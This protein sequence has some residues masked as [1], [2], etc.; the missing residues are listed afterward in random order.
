VRSG[1]GVVVAGGSQDI[2][3]GQDRRMGKDTVVLDKAVNARSAVGGG[4][5][6]EH[7]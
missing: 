1:V 4:E 2:L 5:Q 6:E 7:V 3:E